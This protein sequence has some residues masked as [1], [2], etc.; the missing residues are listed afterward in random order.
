VPAGTPVVEDFTEAV[1]VTVC[2]EVDGFNED[3]TV[4]E[5]AALLTTWCIGAEVLLAKFE[6]PE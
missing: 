3:T 1:K 6:L 2:P 4:V 5:V